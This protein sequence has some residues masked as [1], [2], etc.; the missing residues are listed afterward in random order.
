MASL[1]NEQSSSFI[2]VLSYPSILFQ[3][4]LWISTLC[5]LLK[6]SMATRILIFMGLLEMSQPK[7]FP[8]T[9]SFKSYISVFEMKFLASRIMFIVLHYYYF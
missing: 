8:G 5:D 3:T 6:L 9:G 1:G 7:P 2:F 4:L